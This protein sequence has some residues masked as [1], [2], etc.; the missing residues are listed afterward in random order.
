MGIDKRAIESGASVI[1]LRQREEEFARAGRSRVNRKSDY[2]FVKQLGAQRI[3][4]SAHHF[5]RRP[6]DHAPRPS[7]RKNLPALSILRAA[8]R[9]GQ[10]QA[11]HG[12]RGRP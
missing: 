10:L 11:R 7:P 2:F 3:R 4:L 1:I 9:G 5:S 6:Y 12:G 8:S